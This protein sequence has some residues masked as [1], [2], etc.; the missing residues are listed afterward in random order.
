MAQQNDKKTHRSPLEPIGAS[1]TSTSLQQ[2]VQV[3]ALP[4]TRCLQASG[5][6]VLWLR[7]GTLDVLATVFGIICLPD[8]VK[9][10]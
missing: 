5:D 7:Q 8:L 1:K 2:V 9:D 6:F 3:L 4:F 10:F